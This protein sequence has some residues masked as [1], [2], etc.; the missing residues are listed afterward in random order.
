MPRSRLGELANTVQETVALSV[1][2]RRTP[3]QGS[4]ADKLFSLTS[5]SLALLIVV[6]LFALAVVLIVEAMPSIRRFGLAFLVGTDWDPVNDQ[7]GA[8][9]FIYGTVVSSL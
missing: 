2:V 7:Y 4:A 1:G 6:I 8:L 5:A 3:R 9:P